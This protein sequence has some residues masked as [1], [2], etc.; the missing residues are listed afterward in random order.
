MRGAVAKQEITKKI[1]EVFPN[2]F[3][4]DKII[5]IPIEEDGEIVE[6]KLSMVAAKDVLGGTSQIA[7]PTSNNEAPQK[8]YR[9]N[10]KAV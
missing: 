5:R 9:L 10:E 2:A 8:D 6:I 3:L 7:P 1:F 4:A